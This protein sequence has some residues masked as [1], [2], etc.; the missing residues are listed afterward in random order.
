M[1]SAY[2]HGR[3]EADAPDREHGV[4]GV[5]SSREKGETNDRLIQT[6]EKPAPA[7]LV[8]DKM[9]HA[10]AAGLTDALEGGVAEVPDG[11]GDDV[12]PRHL[13][14]LHHRH[15]QRHHVQRRERLHLRRTRPLQHKV[16]RSETVTFFS[17]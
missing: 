11:L 14:V 6:S 10:S 8:R 7:L 17:R 3:E 9:R 2:L 15:H 1:P 16:H 13:H 4:E 5:C 12:V